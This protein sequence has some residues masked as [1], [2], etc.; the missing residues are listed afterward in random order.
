MVG[1]I[2]FHHY[3]RRREKASAQWYIFKPYRNHG[4]A[5]EAFTALARRIFNGKISEL[6][7][8]SWS[9]KFRKH[10]VNLDFIRAE[11]RETNISSQHVVEVADL[12]S[13]SST[14]IIS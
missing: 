12:L 8:S 6:V 10:S 7:E 4:C 1:D 11:I 5:K 13:N 2:G 3:D 14:V 9:N